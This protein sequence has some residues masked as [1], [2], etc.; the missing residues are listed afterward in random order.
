[1]FQAEVSHTDAINPNASWR[2]RVAESGCVYSFRGP[3]GEAMPPQVHTNA[4]WIDEVW[5]MV[6][7]DPKN[8]P[9]QPYF[10]HQAGSVV[11]RA[12]DSRG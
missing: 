2:L 7:V 6:S 9:T 12:N 11:P 5:Q 3:Y 4:P 8:S 10:I 1:M